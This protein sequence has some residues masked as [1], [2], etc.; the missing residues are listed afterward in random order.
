M[1]ALAIL[2]GG[3]GGADA[4]MLDTVSGGR[5]DAVGFDA[6]SSALPPAD[7]LEGM[8]LE[9]RQEVERVATSQVQRLLLPLVR[10]YRARKLRRERLAEKYSPQHSVPE[11]LKS[12]PLMVHW[13]EDALKRISEVARP[14]SILE[15]EVVLHEGENAGSGV[16]VL[17]R[18]K[19]QVTKR[20]AGVKQC[21]AGHPG[22][23]VLAT[24]EAPQVVGDFTQLTEQPRTA[25]IVACTDCDWAVITKQDFLSELSQLPP[26][27]K[28]SVYDTAF[29][30]RKA[31]MWSMF[32]MEFSDLRKSFL[33]E[34]FTDE[35]L[36]VMTS[37]L[38]P[39]CYRAGEFLCHINTQGA[40]MY[41]LRRGEVDIL[42]PAAPESVDKPEEGEGPAS[43]VEEERPPQES[44]LKKRG[45]MR[46][47]QSLRRV[48]S[49]GFE[50]IKLRSVAQF[51]EGTCFGEFSLVFGEKRSASVRALSH[52]DVWV[53]LFSNLE[54]LFTDPDLRH[55]V[56]HAA[57]QQRLKW[58]V[59]QENKTLKYI[60]HDGNDPDNKDVLLRFMRACPVLRDVCSSRCLADIRRA[61]EPKCYS[62]RDQIISSSNICDR[63]LVMTRGRAVVQQNRHERRQFLHC[64]D[65]VGFTCLAEARW[66]HAVVAQEAC[67][68]WELPRTKLAA[69][70]KEHGQLQK[71]LALIKQLLTSDP[72]RPPCNVT[73]AT[74]PLFPTTADADPMSPPKVLGF[75]AGSS[76]RGHNAD[77]AARLSAAQKH[78]DKG[79]GDPR[80]RRS[81]S[82]AQPEIK[83]DPG[84]DQTNSHASRV[85]RLSSI[86][87]PGLN[88]DMLQRELSR[89]SAESP[90]KAAPRGSVSI[91]GGG[92]VVDSPREGSPLSPG[93]SSDRRR[94]SLSPLAGSKKGQL[95]PIGGERGL[96]L[97]NDQ[98][99][100]AFYSGG[101]WEGFPAS[102]MLRPSREI[103][104][105]SAPGSG[106]DTDLILRAPAPAM[107]SRVEIHAA[108][109]C[110]ANV[111]TGLVWAY[112]A[113]GTELAAKDLRPWNGATEGDWLD[114]SGRVM[115]MGFFEIDSPEGSAGVDLPPGPWNTIALKFLS[116]FGDDTNVDVGAIRLLEDPSGT[117]AGLTSPSAAARRQSSMRGSMSWS[118]RD[119]GRQGSEVL[120]PQ[121]RV[122]NVLGS[123][124]P[125]SPSRRQSRARITDPLTRRASVRDAPESPS[126][127]RRRQ[128]KLVSAG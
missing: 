24:L 101:E 94:S 68:V 47:R 111:R 107:I 106:V 22:N 66:L 115:P 110:S 25:S 20:A 80:L 92:E 91:P 117:A 70:L 7:Q 112:R 56:R 119:A 42:V 3:A 51:K 39:R 58:L 104:H 76:E 96:Q 73:Q 23:V 27:L 88:S 99:S 44:P 84:P 10:F 38:Q 122:S 82:N 26:R 35:Q 118:K 127:G 89:L 59:M 86:G 31:I 87:G 113:G 15:G 4:A 98:F 8:P 40:E 125:E 28:Q 5:F 43:P 21:S 75:V 102:N 19:V 95:Q 55:K 13:T 34:H 72:L 12:S 100:I 18:G 81:V 64:G 6:G 62:Q 121:R 124:S 128:S 48:G 109:G 74:P 50:D 79:S 120:S 63:L 71:A 52:C 108:R 123:T 97:R 45:S 36:G 14:F 1:A 67:D 30:R 114:R 9:V 77:E 37:R 32:P 60:D 85:K 2:E 41:F 49:G 46:R 11:V 83:A 105:C 126:A 33:F 53:L 16:W 93:F 29:A 69:I 103:F 65:V 90:K 78:A 57:H 61:F 116:T 17:L 54:M